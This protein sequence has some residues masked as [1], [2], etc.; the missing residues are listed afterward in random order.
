VRLEG[1][2]EVAMETNILLFVRTAFG[3]TFGGSQ[4]GQHGGQQH[5]ADGHLPGVRP[6]RFA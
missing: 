3:W 6:A 5:A 2:R 1:E 4:I